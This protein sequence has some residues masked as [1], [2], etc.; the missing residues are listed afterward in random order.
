MWTRPALASDLPPLAL[1]MRPADAREIYALRP[2]ADPYALV[3]EIALALPYALWAEV[4]GV[5]GSPSAAAFFAVWPKGR[6]RALGDAALFATREFRALARPLVAHLRGAVM[7]ALVARGVRR[8]E[9]RCMEPH[10]SARAFLLR[11]GARFEARLAD[12]GPDGLAYLQ[13]AWTLSAVA[14]S[15]K[16]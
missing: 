14:P 4:A 1:A 6:S 8:V 3:G 2:S 12:F 5:D 9:A 16:E 11:T 13:F 7:P 15:R 10:R